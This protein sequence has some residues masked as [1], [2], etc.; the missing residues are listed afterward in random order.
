MRVLLSPTEQDLADELKDEAITSSLPEEKGA[1]VLLYTEHGVFGFQRKKCPTDFLTSVEDGRLTRE[2]ALLKQ[3]TFSRLI[4]EE[5]FKYWYDGTVLLGY[6]YEKGKK[7]RIQ[8]RYTK[9]H[10]MGMVN[11]IELVHGVIVKQTEDLK[12]TVAYIRSMHHFMTKS[13]HTGL[14]SRPSAKGTW[15]VPSSKDL[16]LWILQSFPGIGP[17]LAD[18]IIKHFNGEIPLK[19]TC[20]AEQLSQVPRLPKKKAYELIDS[21]LAGETIRHGDERSSSPKVPAPTVDNLNTILSE[22]SSLRGKLGRT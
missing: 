16:H 14:Y 22:F 2:M 5:P 7:V 18:S 21:L 1:D 3:C 13:G 9:N 11:D 19:W 6:K 17:T 20:T 12:D 10:I 4:M 15:Y 8:S